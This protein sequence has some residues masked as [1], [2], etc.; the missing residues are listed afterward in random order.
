MSFNFGTSAAYQ[1]N[2]L[3]DRLVQHDIWHQVAEDALGADHV[4][5]A[6]LRK[7]R[8][9]YWV[10]P[11]QYA[12]GDSGWFYDKPH[13]DFNAT[14]PWTFLADYHSGGA[15]AVGCELTLWKIVNRLLP[16]APHSP[17]PLDP[18]IAIIDCR[19]YP[20]GRDVDRGGRLRSPRDP[21]KC[22]CPERPGLLS[23]KIRF[24]HYPVNSVSCGDDFEP[25]KKAR[26]LLW[27]MLVFA[28]N[29][30]ADGCAVYVICREGRHRS[31]ETCCQILAAH[32]DF[33]YDHISRLRPIV[34]PNFS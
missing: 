34:H 27:E 26:D 33:P 28:A 14:M 6:V 25:C 11:H 23:P 8:E 1:R 7:L 16:P 21:S 24:F 29:C 17:D 31:V 10:L 13:R 15:L 18:L 19:G 12:A 2:V 32:L 22:R 3:A 4:P 20:A 30:I 9:R 5:N